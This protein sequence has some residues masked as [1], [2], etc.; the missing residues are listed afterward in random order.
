[1]IKS[2]SRALTLV[3]LAVVLV[4]GGLPF[5]KGAFYIAKH[6]GDT[7][8]MAEIV[9]RMADGEWPHLDFMTPIGVLAMAP[10][11][12]FV[13]LGWGLGHAI[14]LAQAM[15][16]L[17]LLP[18]T[19]W[20]VQSR[21]QP[22]TGRAA[23]WLY[24]AFVMVLC[25]ALVHGEAETSVSISMH[26]NRW[27]WAIAYLILPLVMIRPAGRDRPAVD[28]TLIG[29]GLAALALSK[30]TY[31]IALAPAILI[32]LMARRWWRVILTA[33]LAGLVVIAILTLWAGPDF[34]LAY[35][36]D[37]LTVSQSE[38]RPRPGDTFG[39]VAASPANMG[40]TLAVLAL[41]IFLRQGER[42][43]EGLI[44]MVLAPGLLYITYQNYGNDPQW[45]PMLAVL[46]LALRPRDGLTN[47][48]G[49]DLRRAVGTVALLA[50]AFG[51]PSAVNLAY[52]PFRH[53][54]AAT[55]KQKPLLAGL[56]QHH[57]VL[58]GESR[59]YGVME[60][61]AGD[62]P[63]SPFAAYRPLAGLENLA[64][65]NGAALPYCEMQSGLSAWFE[66][67]SADLQTA[68]YSGERIFFADLFSQ[69]WMFG[70]FERVEGAAPWYYGG[71]PG[72][73]NADFVLVPLCP[74][75]LRARAGILASL[76]DE[77]YRL[78]EVR[79]TPVYILLSA[80][81]SAP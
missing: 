76:K 41:V 79:R 74:N 47:S 66:T 36:R 19:V 44:L 1:M 62:E 81:K 29:L 24:G 71:L 55:E 40:G 56:P 49:W 32:G 65:L 42:M 64:E 5:L 16:A 59:I 25:L 8:H 12:L 23:G 61:R 18:A 69:L 22:R 10:M 2:E 46:A 17:L 75:F 58:T 37:I 3:L 30:L 67:I 54:A 15:V 72:I 60:S 50:A 4:L 51:Y 20:V 34:W 14:F 78:T 77:G 68:G 53:L 48:L 27:A 7:L 6:E 28:G 43:T 31:F 33:A 73:E 45:L 39:D 57:D 63:G 11:A 70:P 38:L 9:L 21:I 80:E 26:Y 13:R 35:M 52:S